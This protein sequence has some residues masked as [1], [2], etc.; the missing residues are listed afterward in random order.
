VGIGTAVPLQ[1]LHVVGNTRIEGDAIVTGNWEVQ[2]TT[3]Y[4]DTYTAVTSNVTINNASGNGPALRVTQSGV[5]ANYPI[6]DFYDSDVSTTVPALRIADGGN[7]GI[8]TLVPQYKL[9]VEDLVYFPK[10]IISPGIQAQSVLSGGGVVT[11]TGTSLKWSTRVIAIPVEKTE[12][13]GSGLIDIYC[14]L[15]GTIVSY[16]G[17]T[18]VSTV[19]CDANGIPMGFWN[20]L[21]YVVTVGQS[22]ASVQGNFVLTTYT[23]DTWRPTSNWILIAVHNGDGIYGGH[24][25]WMPGQINFPAAGGVYNSLLGTNNWT[26]AVS[27]QASDGTAAAPSISFSS[28]LDT[29]MYRPGDNKLG[30]VTAGIERVSVL[31]NG[32]VGIGTTNPQATLH[33]N[34]SVSIPSGMLQCPGILIGHAFALYGVQFTLSNTFTTFTNTNLTVNYTPKS[35]NSRI[36]ALA[37]FQYQIGAGTTAAIVAFYVNIHRNGVQGSATKFVHSPV[38]GNN[39]WYEMTVIDTWANTST[40]SQTFALY[41]KDYAG[42]L[43]GTFHAGTYGNSIITLFELAN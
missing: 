34:G 14:P 16:L 40:T 25:K 38:N 2:G 42:Y 23:N 13:G 22:A 24:I 39:D 17:A 8:G 26:T 1:K 15:S 37:N 20:A 10:G 5:G 21:W 7:V 4:I 31:D 12:F 41:V 32:N 19:T 28:D 11:W 30:L 3:T 35:N 36:Y 6:A 29:G 43:K 27:V 9:H 18:G 33:V